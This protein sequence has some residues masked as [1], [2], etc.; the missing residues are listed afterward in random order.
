[1]RTMRAVDSIFMSVIEH[2]HHSVTGTS[3]CSYE[4]RLSDLL[5]E[6]W[7]KDDTNYSDDTS[8]DADESAPLR[9]SLSDLKLSAIRFYC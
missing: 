8:I 1:M 2:L 9:T 4:S 3:G 6:G 7:P 5:I